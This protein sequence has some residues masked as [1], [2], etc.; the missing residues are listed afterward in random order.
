MRRTTRRLIRASVPKQDRSGRRGSGTPGSATSRNLRFPL[1][2]ETALSG[3]RR[4]E[5]VRARRHSVNSAGQAEGETPSV[6]SG[7]ERRGGLAGVKSGRRGERD[8]A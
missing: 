1:L 2:P 3:R 5:R 8:E 6:E 7:V 4:Q